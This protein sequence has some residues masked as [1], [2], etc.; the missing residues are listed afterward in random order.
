MPSR[1]LEL[2][3]GA[4]SRPSVIVV[5]AHL[6]QKDVEDAATARLV[7]E[8]NSTLL[9]V[10]QLGSDLRNLEK[11]WVQPRSLVFLLACG[12]GQQSPVTGVGLAGALVRLKATGVIGTECAVYT[13]IASRIAKDVLE[14]MKA[15][16]STPDLEGE[17]VG[18]AL[19]KAVRALALE[20]CP[21]GLAFTYVG[22]IDARLP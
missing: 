7:N 5:L 9:S 16:P 1:F 14:R 21:L 10:H 15:P 13:G 17:S 8:D 6:E 19:R 3:G 18:D 12:S 2:Y 20:G 11:H 22:S 4:V